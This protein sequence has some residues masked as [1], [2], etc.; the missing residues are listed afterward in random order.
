MMRLKKSLQTA[1]WKIGSAASNA[2]LPLWVWAADRL[3]FL[4]KPF[5]RAFYNWILRETAGENAIFKLMNYGYASPGAEDFP[6]SLENADQEEFRFSW[7]LVYETVKHGRLAGKE[8]LVVGCGRGGDAYFVKHYM[9]AKKVTGI[10]FSEAAI[11][12]CRKNYRLEG[13]AFQVGDAEPLAFP[14]RQFDAVVN[15]ESSHCYPSLGKFYREV[16]RVLKPQG[17]FLYADFFWNKRHKKYMEDAGFSISEE[18]I[19]QNIVLAAERGYDL[20]KEWIKKVVPERLFNEALEWSGTK[21]TQMYRRFKKG[22]LPYKR[23]V[24]VRG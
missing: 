6:I 23:F 3:P 5:K 24:L 21:G 7:Q 16:H 19:T 1:A 8:V 17:V 14:D 20:R 22:R 15:I 9:N 13:L 4:K 11:E 2:G 10:D 12:I 18:D